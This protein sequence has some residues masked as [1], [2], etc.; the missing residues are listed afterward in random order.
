MLI[1]DKPVRVHLDHEPGQW[2]DVIAP[3]V[4]QY[5]AA[6][7]SVGSE[8]TRGET[9][10]ALARVCVVGWSYDAPVTPGNVDRLDSESAAV[11]FGALAEI[12]SGASA[13][14]NPT[15]GASTTPSTV[16]RARRTNG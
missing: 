4:V 3:S 8:G 13:E 12:V 11:L 16:R 1:S 10:H 5:L 7:K 15:G 6:S 9:L 2:I 14:G